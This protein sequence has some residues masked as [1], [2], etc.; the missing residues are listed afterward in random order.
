MRL[1][2]QGEGAK[3]AVNKLVLAIL[4]TIT[5]IMVARKS[6]TQRDTLMAN[7]THDRNGCE[8]RGRKADPM[9]VS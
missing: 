5:V 4:F 9:K 8:L 1:N 3:L 6:S 7:G 2:N